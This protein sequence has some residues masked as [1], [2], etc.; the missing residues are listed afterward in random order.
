MG[1][2]GQEGGNHVYLWLIHA[3]VWQKPAQQWKAIILQ[4][5]INTLNTGLPWWL[6]G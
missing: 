4:I 1:G 6:G 2:G 3:E 5:K